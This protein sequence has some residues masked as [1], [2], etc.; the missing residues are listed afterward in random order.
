MCKTPSW[1][2]EPWPLPPYSISIYTDLEI[3]ILNS[4]VSP[5]KKKKVHK[6]MQHSSTFPYFINQKFPQPMLNIPQRF[7]LYKPK[8]SNSVLDIEDQ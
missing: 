4:L 8:V 2:L 1:R 5:K 6:P 7:L 3:L